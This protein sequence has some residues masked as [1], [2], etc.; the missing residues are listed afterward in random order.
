MLSYPIWA[1]SQ[2]APLLLTATRIPFFPIHYHFHVPSAVQ[3]PLNPLPVVF[4]PKAV[5]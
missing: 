5:F 4:N 2:R 3:F 1:L